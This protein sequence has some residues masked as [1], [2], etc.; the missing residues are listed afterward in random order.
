MENKGQGRSMTCGKCCAVFTDLVEF[1]NHRRGNDCRSPADCSSDSLSESEDQSDYDD[2]YSKSYHRAISG[3]ADA[4]EMSDS[5]EEW[6]PSDTSGEDENDDD[7]ASSQDEDD[8]LWA[9]SDP[10]SVSKMKGGKPFQCKE[11]GK[12]FDWS[13][14]LRRHFFI[15]TGERP[16]KCASCDYGTTEMGNL[17]RHRRKMHKDENPFQCQLCFTT[18][19]N[20]HDQKQHEKIECDHH[21]ARR[22]N[23]KEKN[24]M[25]TRIQRPEIRVKRQPEIAVERLFECGGCSSAFSTH[26]LLEKHKLFH[27]GDVLKKFPCDQC[28]RAFDW[29]C[30]LERHMRSH[31]IIK[32]FACASCDYAAT[33]M[34]NLTR[35]RRLMHE[36]EDPYQCCICNSTFQDDNQMKKHVKY[37]CKCQDTKPRKCEKCSAKFATKDQLATHQENCRGKRKKKLKDGILEEPD[38]AMSCE[39]ETRE[40]FQCEQCGVYLSSESLVQK[41]ML[42]HSGEISEKYPCDQC[43]KAFHWVSQ[44][45]RHASFHRGEKRFFCAS[46]DYAATESAAVIKHRRSWHEGENAYQCHRCYSTFKDNE[47]LKFHRNN[48]CRKPIKCRLCH[49]TCATREEFLKHSFCLTKRPKKHQ[50]NVCGKVFAGRSLLKNHMF[51]HT[52]GVKKYACQDCD[53]SFDLS[54]SLM[55]H[56]MK[57]TGE[58]PFKCSI[59][60]YAATDM[61]NLKRHL[62]L[63][64][65]RKHQYQCEKCAKCF[66]AQHV[67]ESHLEQGCIAANSSI[68]G[69]KA[70]LHQ[71]EKCSKCFSSAFILERHLLYHE[72]F[73]CDECDKS[74]STEIELKSHHQE[75]HENRLVT[76]S[77]L[78]FKCSSCNY[79]TA[80]M[81]SFTIHLRK[82]H[83][84][85]NE[86]LFTCEVCNKTFKG[87]SQLKAHVR[88]H[89]GEKPYRCSLCDFKA[90]EMGRL[91]R[92]RRSCH[93]DKK[94]YQCE[95]CFET[96]D[97]AKQ[98]TFHARRVYKCTYVKLEPEAETNLANMEIH[99]SQPETYSC[100]ECGRDFLSR[101]RLKKHLLLHPGKPYYCEHCFRLFKERQEL[102]AHAQETCSERKANAEMDKSKLNKCIHCFKSFTSQSLLRSH[103]VRVHSSRDEKPFKCDHCDYAAFVKDNLA[104]HALQHSA[105]KPHHCQL[106]PESFAK[107]YLLT[108]HM[109]QSHRNGTAQQKRKRRKSSRSGTSV[110]I[111]RELYECQYC[112]L[113]FDEVWELNLHIAE[114]HRETLQQAENMN[115]MT[116]QQAENKNT[117][118]LQPP[119]EGTIQQDNNVQ[120]TISHDLDAHDNDDTLGFDEGIFSN[121]SYSFDEDVMVNIGDEL[122]KLKPLNYVVYENDVPTEV[123]PS[124]VTVTTTT[125]KDAPQMCIEKTEEE[126]EIDVETMEDD[127]KTVGGNTET[128]EDDVETVGGDMETVEEDNN[129]LPQQNVV[130]CDELHSQEE[131]QTNIVAVHGGE[132]QYNST[133]HSLNAFLDNSLLDIT[134]KLQLSDQQLEYTQDP[135]INEET[136]ENRQERVMGNTS[137]VRDDEMLSEYDVVVGETSEDYDVV[138]VEL[139]NDEL[140]ESS[141]VHNGGEIVVKSSPVH[142]EI[143]NEKKESLVAQSSPIDGVATVGKLTLKDETIEDKDGVVARVDEVPTQDNNYDDNIDDDHMLTE[144]GSTSGKDASPQSEKEKHNQSSVAFMK[145]I[146][147]SA[148]HDRKSKAKKTEVTSSDKNMRRPFRCG[149][150]NT[151]FAAKEILMKHMLKHSGQ[152]KPYQC[153]ICDRRFVSKQSLSDHIYIHTGEKPYVCETCGKRFSHRSAAFTHRQ[154]HNTK[155]KYVCGICNK[156]FTVKSSLI[157]HLDKHNSDTPYKCGKCDK[158]FKTRAGLSSHTTRFHSEGRPHQ[159]DQCGKLFTRLGFLNLHKERRAGGRGCHLA[160]NKP[161]K[162]DVCGKSLFNRSSLKGHMLIH[163]G[164]KPNECT[165]CGKKFRCKGTLNVHMLTHSAERPFLC[166]ECGKGFKRRIWLRLHCQRSHSKVKKPHEYTRC[167]QTFTTRRSLYV[168]VR[169]HDVQPYLCSYCD[170]VF[171]E[172][173]QLRH[174]LKTHEKLKH[175]SDHRFKSFNSTTNL[176]GHLETCET[177]SNQPFKLLNSTKNLVGHLTTLDKSNKQLGKPFNSNTSSVDNLKTHDDKSNGQLVKSVNLTTNSETHDK[178][179]KQFCKPF[180]S[181]WKSSCKGEI[182]Q[183]YE[184]VFCGSS[185]SDKRS[186]GEHFQAFHAGDVILDCV[187]SIP[188]TVNGPT[189]QLE[190]TGHPDLTTEGQGPPLTYT[191]ESAPTDTELLDFTMI[192]GTSHPSDITAPVTLTRTPTLPGTVTTT[193]KGTARPGT[194][195]KATKPLF[196]PGKAGSVA[197][198]RTTPGSV[199]Q[200]RTTP[201]SVAQTRTTPGSVAQTRTTRGSV[202]Q[203]RTAPGSVAQTRTTTGSVAQTRTTPGI[204]TQTTAAPGNVAQ[205]RTTP[206]SVTQTRTAPGNVAQTRTTPGSVTQTRATPGSVTQTGTPQNRAIRPLLA[207]PINPAVTGTTA[208]S[209]L[210]K[211]TTQTVGSHNRIT[212]PFVVSGSPAT[213]MRTTGSQSLTGKIGSVTLN[214]TAGGTTLT[215]P[216]GSGSIIRTAGPSSPNVQRKIVIPSTGGAVGAPQQQELEATRGQNVLLVVVNR[217]K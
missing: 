168:H 132:M 177:I 8:E 110:S 121:L 130:I 83:H 193:V 183:R 119:P 154:S 151:S 1:M 9:P 78:P 81:R 61:R 141:L 52:H 217:N 67:L 179:N 106:C 202:A 34:A 38:G 112:K 145:D 68:P 47:R 37:E 80:H 55:R 96:F 29:L 207:K 181:T 215:R 105:D 180:Q 146:M 76:T 117:A 72:V 214:R 149:L 99:E 189:I 162:C 53:M 62:S 101:L 134:N 116:S 153:E 4:G 84:Q 21:L 196:P 203:T 19:T 51:Y 75:E 126:D 66:K 129:L 30:Q 24:K 98:M 156:G 12:T 166:A 155:R 195:M 163:S 111:S 48:E 206:G 63:I 169:T 7:V 27:T 175:T 201:R 186:L 85:E 192:T 182:A 216:V 14:Q 143:M 139:P 5:D 91:T 2:L 210:N 17:T 211:V 197:Q 18:F 87:S 150:C 128:L 90:S 118:T 191:M 131:E 13:A 212:V 138:H 184:C 59:C 60:N 44:L 170:K 174:H 93:R 147:G 82:Y 109:K 20:L 16:F 160:R 56:R 31:A 50:C 120:S 65:S 32:P 140:G 86:K 107:G 46:C 15:H 114:D 71:C 205:T 115:A 69:K 164:E 54:S 136:L 10:S 133:Y 41:H 42:F 6:T 94:P 190:L 97:K 64:H 102:D 200:T 43:D 159:C 188:S 39:E 40:Q 199:A 88:M 33:E 103:M 171:T 28:D 58:R 158:M 74:F 104:R 185:F 165:K 142:N 161:V 45:E 92:H 77:E 122:V 172:I 208:P 198:T 124:E 36:D 209:V 137:I 70:S 25:R 148:R 79:A 178:S 127:V 100:K 144:D 187:N 57:H 194:L 108:K 26:S 123:T 173:T 135:E 213:V 73:K 113:L 204:I 23:E 152:N 35:H 125:P 22:K 95:R 89:T 167:Q 176:N 157:G 3:D 11:C 49:K